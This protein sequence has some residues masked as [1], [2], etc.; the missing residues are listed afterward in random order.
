M[1]PRRACFDHTANHLVDWHS[2]GGTL[3]E[4]IW[5]IPAFL[6]HQIVKCTPED[7]MGFNCDRATV[8]SFRYSKDIGRGVG[9]QRGQP[10][11]FDD[12]RRVPVCPARY[13]FRP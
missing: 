12:A 9:L 8:C 10:G 3:H 2:H 13:D 11:V 4:N 7:Q 1:R 6:L 5:H